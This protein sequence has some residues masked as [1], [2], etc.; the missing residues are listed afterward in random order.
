[1]VA[2]QPEHLEGDH[3]RGGG[4]ARQAGADQLHTSPWLV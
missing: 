1:V 4:G 2:G 3:L